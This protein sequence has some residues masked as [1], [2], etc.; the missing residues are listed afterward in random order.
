M[1]DKILATITSKDQ[2]AVPAQHRKA[3]GLKS[4][5]R[6]D[7]DPPGEKSDRIEPRRKRSIFERLDE[8]KLPPLGRP[9]T[10]KDI[11]DSVAEAMIEKDQRSRQKR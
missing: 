11:D 7:V 6:I 3:S 10:Q 9:L 5:D 1:A 2:I 4:G 8:L